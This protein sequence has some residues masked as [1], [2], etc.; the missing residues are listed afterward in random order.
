MTTPD[1]GA[2][3]FA[4]HAE[5]LHA[6]G[7]PVD[8]ARERGYVSAQHKAD[9]ARRGFA[10]SQRIV[11]ALVIPLHSVSGEVV[12]YQARP[13]EPRMKNGK[14]VK[15]E[16]PAG[17]T[18]QLDVHPRA[19]PVIGNP[20]IPLVITEGVRKADAAVAADLC[21]VAL[22]GVTAWRGTNDEGGKVALAAWN[23]VALNGRQTY[24][25]FDSDVMTKPAVH[26][27]LANFM[28]FL[29][30]KGA[31]VAVI[32]L[33]CGPHGEKVGLDDYLAAGHTTDELF[34]LA[35]PELR[36]LPV[37]DVDVID[38]RPAKPDVAKMSLADV[39]DAFT[40]WLEMDDLDPLFAVLGTYA[41]LHLDG[42]PVWLMVVGGSGRGKTEIVQSLAG[43]VDV[44][45]A[46]SISG[47]AA[48]LSGTPTKDRSVGATGGLLRQLG[49]LGMLVI[50]DFTSIL[51]M[52]REARAAVLGALREVYDG[53][54]D[55]NI[56]SDGGRQMRW[57]GKA[58]LVA[59]CTTAID[60]AHA[61]I[62][63]MGERFLLVRL[64]EE[65][66]DQLA[67]RAL[68]QAGREAT[69]RAELADTVA[70]LF[71]DGL[72]RQPTPLTLPERERLVRLAGLVA[73]ARS[74]VERD[75]QGEI[76]LVLDPEAPTRLAKALERL[77]SGLDAI[78]VDRSDAWKVVARVG[79]DSVPK[80]RGAVVRA[81]AAGQQSTTSVA[82]AVDHPNR[83]T[84]RAL[85]DLAAHH[86]VDRTPQ[87][88]GKADLWAL[89]D[90][91][92][93]RYAEAT[94]VPETSD[95][96]HEV[97]R[98][99]APRGGSNEPEHTYDDITG[100][101]SDREVFLI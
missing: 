72:P 13:D 35:S 39:V 101:V 8:V 50:K 47:E 33:P 18:M 76:E 94:T 6:S 37:V 88:R 7:I 75:Y 74:P 90:W 9:L 62:A 81:L 91:A 51:S 93:A 70:G 66:R 82:K 41:A 48:L 20:K 42:D 38:Q 19:L 4:Q 98:A 65:D 56:G 80:L 43:N 23:V 96:E 16:Q 28:A 71:V 26:Q 89:T 79:L 40:R 100:K 34:A 36:P 53:R 83:T 31:D 60:K 99:A 32:Y 63:Q 55:R 29:T 84:L 67:R 54:W 59:G 24:I 52:H 21:C 1:Y 92:V 22:L 73:Q 45:A 49:D 14:I 69:M 95:T 12:G 10:V 87:G 85:E 77:W 2:G 3:V 5:L 25:V 30:F 57:T 86:V 15:Y 78:G 27:A 17:A 44:V 64:N 68:D 97:V 11:P 58:G 61:V 46:S